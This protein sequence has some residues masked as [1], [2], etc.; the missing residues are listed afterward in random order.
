MPLNEVLALGRV[1]VSQL[2]Q[3]ALHFGPQKL[4]VHPLLGLS[5]LILLLLLF[6]LHLG[7][8]LV[9]VVDSRPCASGSRFQMAGRRDVDLTGSASAP[10]CGEVV[11]VVVKGRRGIGQLRGKIFCLLVFS[12]R[13]LGG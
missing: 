1:E 7:F 3:K 10:G 11:F 4:S 9:V 2:P 6:H 12:G 8:L 5:L 13:G